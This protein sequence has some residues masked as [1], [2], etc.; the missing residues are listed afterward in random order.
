MTQDRAQKIIIAVLALLLVVVSGALVSQ[1]FFAK[2]A[3]PVAV[4]P[5]ENNKNTPRTNTNV[6]INENQNSNT[7]DIRPSTINESPV[8]LS[9]AWLSTGTDIGF[10]AFDALFHVTDKLSPD[11]ALYAYKV[12][13]VASGEYVGQNIYQ[14]ENGYTEN[15]STYLNFLTL[16]IAIP[17]QNKI[18]LIDKY[19]NLDLS[20]ADRKQLPAI[21]DIAFNDPNISIPDLAPTPDKITIK[22]SNYTA[23]RVGSGNGFPDNNNMVAIIGTTSDNLPIYDHATNTTYDGMRPPPNNDLALRLKDGELI[24]YSLQIPFFTDGRIPAIK[25]ND[26]K[27]NTVDY[28]PYV[29]GQCGIGDTLNQA[30]VLAKDLVSG[31]TTSNGETIFV[32]KDTNNKYLKDTYA[33]WNASPYDQDADRSYAGFLAKRPY[34][35]WKDPFGRLIQWARPDMNTLAECGKP[36]VYLY[37]TKTE[38]VNVKLGNNIIV[39]KSAP[40]YKNGWKVTAEPNGV[41]T[42]ADGQTYP[43]LYWDGVGASYQTPTTGFVVARSDIEATLKSKLTQLGLNKK[44]ISDFTG[45]WLPIVTKS[46]YALISF[47]PQDEWSKAAPLA[48]SPA[49]KT[50]IRVF[51]DWKPLSEPISIAPQILPPTPSRTG[52]T[53]V[54]W[55][56]LLYR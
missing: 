30:G 47:V 28:T 36:V 33:T 26:G 35:F 5:V 41:L 55:G 42:S 34:F 8:D 1:A 23:V 51:M 39:E 50:V 14:L 56:G 11:D 12:G 54:E 49:P 25:W 2:T 13:T 53:A 48:I 7:P 21:F 38:Q 52:F 29:E 37:P 3:A 15:G 32:Y 22:G 9:I 6:V 4:A 19:S 16:A 45:F 10:D 43:Y 27:N 31:G 17:S 24:Q 18:I 40:A 46:P 44:E 20:T